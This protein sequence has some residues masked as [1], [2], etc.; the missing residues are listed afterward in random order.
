[1][2]Y[3]ALISVKHTQIFRENRD[4]AKV[5]GSRLGNLVLARNL[6]VHC[7]M[8]ILVRSSLLTS[9]YIMEGVFYICVS[10]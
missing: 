3:S 9:S 4:M 7:D 8:M 6:L 10:I 2:R 5:M 1:M